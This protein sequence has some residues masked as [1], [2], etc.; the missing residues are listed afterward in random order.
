MPVTKAPPAKRSRFLINDIL[1]VEDNSNTNPLN[2][3][4]S[5]QIGMGSLENF[6]EKIDS[7]KVLCKRFKLMKCVSKFAI[8]NVPENPEELLRRIINDCISA[9]IKD[10]KENDI[11]VNHM[12]ATISSILLDSDIWIPIRKL[13]IDTTENILQRFLLVSQSKAERGSLW[14]EPFSISIHTI[15]VPPI[16]KNMRVEGRAPNNLNSQNG[17]ENVE[18]WLIRVRNFNNNYC[19]FYAMELTRKYFTEELGHRRNFSRY[20]LHQTQQQQRDVLKLMEN[21]HIPMGESTYNA[22]TY[23]PLVVNYWNEYYSQKGYRFKVFIFG[24]KGEV[25]PIYKFGHD[26]FNTPIPIYHS[27]DHFD[28]IRT[29]GAQFGRHWQYCYSCEKKYVMARDHDKKCKSRCRLCGRVGLERPCKITQTFKKECLEC[30]KTF[31][32]SECFNYHKKSNQCKNSKQCKNCGVIWNIKDYQR[33]PSK[34]HICGH[35]WCL[36]CRQFHSY[37]RGCYIRPLERKKKIPYRL[38]TFDFEATQHTE[39]TERPNHRLHCVNFIAATI[40]CTS[41]MNDEQCWRGYL[42]R[43]NKICAICGQN[44]SITF[45]HRAFKNTFVDEKRIT[46]NPL[47]DFVNWLLFELDGRFLTMAF[48]HFGGKYDMVMTFREIFLKGIV[49]SMIRRGNKLYELRVPRSKKCN[50]IIF[51]DS[52]NL[53]P[54]ALGELVGAFDLKITEKQFFPHLANNPKNYDITLSSLPPKSD[55][56]YEGMMPA[57]QKVFNNWYEQEKHS[58]FCLN[59]ALAEYCLNDVQILTEALLAFRNK[60]LIISSKNLDSDTGIDILKDAMT[61]ASGCM[62]HFRLN[63]LKHEHLAIVPEK[64]YDTCDTQSE[65]AFK[66]LDWYAEQ[67]NV[68]IR[69]A[70]SE[71]GEYCVAG[72]FKVDGYI[73]AEDRA[74]EV[75]GCV[76]HA[77]PKHYGDRPNHVMPNG[78]T[79]ETIQNEDKER[80]NILRQHIK[81]VEVVWEC[82]INKMLRQNKKMKKC[83]SDYIDKG[84]INIRDCFFGG[85]TG[86]F[87]LHFEANEQQKISY[88][89]F[90]S[91]YPSTLA[92]TSFPIGHPRVIIVP[93]QDQHVNWQN[94]VHIPVKGIL[95]VF[96]IP[97]HRVNI[98]VMPVKFDDR[99]LFPLCRRCSLDF[100]RGGTKT[101]Y[102]CTHNDNERGWVSTCTSI[103]LAEA[104]DNGYRVTRYFRALHYEKWDDKLF[105]EYVSEF[106]SMKI[107]ASGFPEG[108]DTI[109]EENKFMEECEGKFG[110]H[111]E[112]EKMLPDKAMRYISKL[113]LNSLWGRFSLRNTLNKS[114]ITDSPN[115][116]HEFLRNK[117]IEVNSLDK[118][119]EDTILITY[120][121]K[122]E[123]IEEHPT[124]NIVISLWTTSKARI[125]LLHAMQKITDTPGCSL[126]YGDTDSVLFAYPKNIQCPLVSGPYLG[127]LAEEYADY[128]IREYVGAACKAYGLRMFENHTGDEKTTLRVRGITLN[129]D[130][131]KR[132]NYSSFKECVMSFGRLYNDNEEEEM[133]VDVILAHY[134]NFIRPNLKAGQ[135]CS[136]PLSKTFRPVILKGIVIPGYKIVDFGRK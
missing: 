87:C 108:I 114:H 28:G 25:K 11:D 65:L 106:M 39:I 84:P 88:L 49:P 54:V 136:A 14:G 99:L 35:R 80:L 91:L 40:T 42:R 30:G 18:S 13:Q 22:K 59:E 117:S 31:W 110:I 55:Y 10:A 6:I 66:Y 69:T 76:W 17:I 105:K 8:K 85:R 53:C 61:I 125:H 102:R 5:I 97:P 74:I 122:K 48:S 27:N 121:P 15:Q 72:R 73:E 128:S 51:R 57:K 70:H 134:P 67:H 44:R 127:D 20:H 100:P 130:V 82:D 94:S 32:N 90:N 112:R 109:E 1:G 29:V 101:E 52:Y 81:H 119:T 38:V 56:L 34:K 62:K 47:H 95:K 113:M 78:K 126:L 124:S 3:Q 37:D 77:C 118:L 24:N 129:A 89:D 46:D 71:N 7:S 33:E 9:A 2:N 107:H 131:C 50:E 45:S 75:H 111:L 115:E 120:E 116:V 92:T 12:G 123:F 19:L 63:H 133:Q 86:P 43:E 96:L 98:P 41:C 79:V 83:F 58:T 60:F 132:I 103:E 93:R 26:M 104:L 16:D 64:G 135:I 21:A 23:I 4:R 68:N 36:T